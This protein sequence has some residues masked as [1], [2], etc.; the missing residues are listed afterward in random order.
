[1]LNSNL[2]AAQ[3]AWCR[4]KEPASSFAGAGVST[5]LRVPCSVSLPANCRWQDERQHW[6][7]REA[8]LLQHIQTLHSQLTTLATAGAGQQLAQQQPLEAQPP[9]VTAWRCVGSASSMPGCSSEQAHEK[10]LFYS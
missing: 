9:Q 4:L 8:A 5:Q 1:M 2:L 3:A 10:L 6:H 7:K